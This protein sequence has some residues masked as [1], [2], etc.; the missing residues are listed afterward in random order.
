VES[1]NR[2]RGSQRLPLRFR[3]A[4]EREE[5][6]AAFSKARHHARAALG[7]C[8]LENR[9]GG[10]GGVATGGID[11]PMEVVA[12]VRERVLRSFTFEVAQFVDA[13]ALNHSPRPHQPDGAPEPGI[14]VDD[15]QHWRPQSSRDKIVEAALPGRERLASAQFQ[16]EQMLMPVGQDADH[17]KH[18]HA[19]YSSGTAHAQ[20]EAIEVDV[21][22]VEIDK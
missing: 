13:A 20:S 12:N 17:A 5:F 14:P 7:P 1:L 11:D 3:E 15:R 8:A 10:A 4:K 22:D 6:V 21:D 2:V 16:G 18:R 9:V 19:H